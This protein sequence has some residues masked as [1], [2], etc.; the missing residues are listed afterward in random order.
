MPDFGS[1]KNTIMIVPPMFASEVFVV[2]TAKLCG[3]ILLILDVLLMSVL[4]KTFSLYASTPNGEIYPLPNVLSR[5][6]NVRLA[7]FRDHHHPHQDQYH[8][9]HQQRP[10]RVNFSQ[11]RTK[12]D[13][14]PFPDLFPLLLMMAD[15]SPSLR[16]LLQEAGSQCRGLCPWMTVDGSQFPDLLA[17]L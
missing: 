8:H 9:P 5:L 17:L 11:S 12:A 6:A 16:G 13:G 14:A 3:E 15:G 4:P 7:D 2:I 1:M 10:D